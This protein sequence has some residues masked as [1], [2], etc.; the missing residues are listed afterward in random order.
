MRRALCTAARATAA[1][2]AFAFCAAVWLAIGLGGL[3]VLRAVAAA[4]TG[5]VP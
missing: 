2:A 1:L 3:A 4:V 5:I